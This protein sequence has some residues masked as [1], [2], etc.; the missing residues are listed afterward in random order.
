LSIT[1]LAEIEKAF[2]EVA[3]PDD[4]HIVV[5]SSAASLEGQE[6]RRDFASRDWRSLR[7]E[8]LRRHSSSLFLLTPEAFRYF[9]PAY[10]SVSISDREKADV[11]PETLVFAF[12]PDAGSPESS[13]YKAQLLQSLTPAQKRTIGGFLGWLETADD[14]RSADAVRKVKKHYLA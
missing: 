4:D 2:A 9:L 11:I 14:P 12:D 5:A 6:I 8:E 1:V 7:V 3:R 13:A 10:M